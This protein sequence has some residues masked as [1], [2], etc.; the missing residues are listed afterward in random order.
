MAD[1]LELRKLLYEVA[2]KEVLLET[3]EAKQ[4]ALAALQ[5]RWA[6]DWSNGNLADA[7]EKRNLFLEIE[8]HVPLETIFN[9]LD[10]R[11]L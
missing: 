3:L 10:S 7:T 5:Y 2:V 6:A 11:D 4:K 8:C 1:S 9:Y